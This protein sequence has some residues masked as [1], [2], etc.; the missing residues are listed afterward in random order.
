[1]SMLL[2]RGCVGLLVGSVV[3]AGAALPGAQSSAAS[4]G[5]FERVVTLGDSYSSGTGSHADASDYDDHGP[6]GHFFSAS[7]RLGSSDC[8][9]ELDTTP[10]PRLADE[11]GATAVFIACA[12]AV[13]AH[14]PN[15]IEAAQIVGDGTGTLVT[16]TVG[17]NDIRTADSSTWSSVLVKCISSWRCDRSDGNQPDNLDGIRV[18]LTD[19]YSE[20]G[21]QYPGITV[22]ILGYPRLMQSDRWCEG[23][24]GISRSEANWIDAQADRLNAQIRGAAVAARLATG[25]DIQFV[26]VVEEFNNHGAC[27]FWQRDRYV[28]DTVF[29]ETLKRSMTEDGEIHDHWSDGLFNISASSFHPSSKGYDAY[30]A[31]LKDSLSVTTGAA[32]P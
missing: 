6:A 9:R 19:L 12:G 21:D 11:F 17:G 30:Y 23:V 7:E 15:Q 29:G 24:G 27:R 26:S 16:V 2:R 28:H 18:A 14:I 13:A 25:T 20:I 22:R 8:V 3:A 1:M 4:V 5:G 10:G 32:L 31:A